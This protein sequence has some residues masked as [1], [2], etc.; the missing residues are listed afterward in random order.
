MKERVRVRVPASTSNCGSGFDCL[1]LALNLYGQLGLEAR[2]GS[3]IR[4]VGEGSFG[5][6]GLKLVNMAAK[7]FFETSGIEPVGFDFDTYSDIPMDR[8]L[9]SSGVLV[10]G[11]LGA[12]NALFEQ[13]LSS[14][15]L[16]EQGTLVEG[17]P[18]N[19][20]AGIFGGF[21]VARFCPEKKRYL[22]TQRFDVAK[23]LHFLVLSP[24]LSMRTEASRAML[25]R[26]LG[27]RKVVSSINSVAYLIAA[28]ASQNYACLRAG[29]TDHL[30]EPYRLPQ[31]FGGQE[32]LDAGIKAGALT[33]WLSGSGSS[34]L[35]VAQA[36]QAAAVQEAMEAVFKGR[37]QAYRIFDLHADNEGLMT[38]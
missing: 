29:N 18:D 2:S 33:G 17:H 13:P 19:V 7:A 26:E 21:T 12:L 37:N 4:Y 31:V 11:I 32:C 8:G 23:D 27:F 10:A 5:E 1:G 35:C 24:E 15:Q 9:G 36:D 34:L 3:N 6:G 14:E 20:A 16:V 30:H 25:P 22:G 38:F 28:F